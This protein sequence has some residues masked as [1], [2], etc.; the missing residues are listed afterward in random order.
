MSEEEGTVF[1]EDL[2]NIT[3]SRNLNDENRISTGNTEGKHS[4]ARRINDSFLLSPLH[5]AERFQDL[6]IDM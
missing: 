6:A 1:M 3:F 2:S 5:R 4:Q